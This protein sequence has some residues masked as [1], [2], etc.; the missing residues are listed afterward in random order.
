MERVMQRYFFDLVMD[1]PAGAAVPQYDY[2][3]RDF[4]CLQ[5][6]SDFAELW[7]MDLTM[8]PDEPWR[9]WTVKVRNTQGQL[10]FSTMVSLFENVPDAIIEDSESR[11]R[12]SVRRHREP[13]AAAMPSVATTIAATGAFGSPS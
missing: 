5:A 7:A 13:A 9:G 12:H 4:S 1:N 6:A 3:G 10:L 8:E 11:N 2:G